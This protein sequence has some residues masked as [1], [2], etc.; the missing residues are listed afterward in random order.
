MKR[1]T[2]LR[3]ANA[4]WKDSRIADFDRPLNRRGVSES[5]AM[6]K[7]L[8]EREL[9][10]E[11]VLTSPALRAQQ[12]T[13]IFMR[14][15][16]LPARKLRRDDRLYLAQPEDILE[17]IRT[18]G[19]RITHLMVVGHNPGLT[20]LARRLAPDG[21]L[22]ELPTASVCTML[23]DVR[24]WVDIEPG[25]AKGVECEAPKGGFGFW[26]ALSTRAR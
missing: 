6:A 19:P 5:T 24:A 15:F 10:P 18:T 20:D 9:V 11:F 17:A 13:E 23:F 2:L 21:T 22:V 3:H 1:L 25:R 16:E 12:T 26:S 7:R 4:D 8:F 14:E